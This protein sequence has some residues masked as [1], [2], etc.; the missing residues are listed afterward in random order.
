MTEIRLELGINAQK[1]IQQVQIN[2]ESIE[3]QIEK[4][5][6]LALDDIIKGDNFIQ[7]VREATKEELRNIVNKHV[8]SY[9]VRNRIEKL[10]SDKISQKVEQYADKIAEQVTSVLR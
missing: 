6:Q 8:M 4:G 5:I 9:D 7:G 1:F 3:A 10:V 2:N